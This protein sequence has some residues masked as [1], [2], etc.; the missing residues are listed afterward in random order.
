VD[1]SWFTFITYVSVVT[2]I[3]FITYVS[4]VTFITFITYV[5]KYMIILIG[6]QKG[7][8][9]KSTFAVNISGYLS[10][11]GKDVCLVD[12]DPQQ[13][14]LRWAQYREENES[15][16]SINCVSASGNITKTLRDL[17]KRYEVIVCDVAGKDSSELRSGL[18]A[19]DLFIS[20][21]RPSQF[22]LETLP[23]LVDV[24]NTAK[25]FNNDLIGYLVLNL[26]PTLPTIKEAE[27]AEIIINKNSS[28]LLSKVRIHDRKSYRDSASEG[29]SVFEWKD[30]KAQNEIQWLIEEVTG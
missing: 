29:L 26:C 18:V 6:S 10:S 30:K 13:S 11:Q 23:H 15:L 2:F 12:A 17:S 1:R 25:D 24:F 22:D 9:G 8:C 7:G 21:M 16:S 20:P 3:T 5:I 14:S 28:L 27:Q 4:V 19:S